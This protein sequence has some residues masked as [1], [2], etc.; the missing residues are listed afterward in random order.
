MEKSKASQAWAGI[1]ALAIEFNRMAIELD[2]KAEELQR[3]CRQHAQLL[4]DTNSRE[5]LGD[6]EAL[7]YV[8]WCDI[9]APYLI[10][11][12]TIRESRRERNTPATLALMEQ[13]SSTANPEP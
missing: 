3:V 5:P 9:I 6:A 13:H 8:P 4:K 10:R 7:R 1:E 11:C 2:A 12:I